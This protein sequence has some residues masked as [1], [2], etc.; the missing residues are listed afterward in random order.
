[1][2]FTKVEGLWVPCPPPGDPIL[3]FV[4]ESYLSAESGFI[5]SCVAVTRDAYQNAIIPEARRLLG[6]LGSTAKEFKAS[7]L[8][9]GN[10]TVYTDFLQL[11][12][13]HMAAVS[14]ASQMCSIIT[15][16]AWGPYQG[17]NFRWLLPQV[18]GAM[19][20]LGLKNT[21]KLAAEFTRQILWLY[22]HWPKLCGRKYKNPL[23]VVFDN[24]HS[25]AKECR[26]LQFVSAPGTPAILQAVNRTLTSF[27][28]SLF[29]ILEPRRDV[30][31]IQDFTFAWSEDECGIQAAD[32]LS[33]VT[34]N[35]LKHS[36]GISSPTVQLRGDV[37]RS[38]MPAFSAPPDLQNALRR[39]GNDLVCTDA[40][41]LSTFRLEAGN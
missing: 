12:V 36:L 26:E 4:D 33:N 30:S 5:Q 9:A 28:N 31:S 29:R 23:I 13:N 35:A 41:L 8:K 3:L 17:N 24:K 37:L 34:L 39:K 32:L 11:F 7:K 27:A 1:M 18:V 21:D 2:P 20:N 14:D 38:L 15:V 22:N 19:Q 6:R 10:V 25:Y 16:D 40:A